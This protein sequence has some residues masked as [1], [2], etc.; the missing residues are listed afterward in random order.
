MDANKITARLWTGAALQPGD[1]ATMQAAGITHVIDCRSEGGDDSHVLGANF[2]TLWNPTADDGAPKTADWF[3]R[4][5]YFAMGALHEPK[6]VVLAH[7]AA[8]VN[9]GPST[10]YAILLSF[11]IDKA[12]AEQLIR[13]ARPQVG[14]RYKADAEAAV[15]GLLS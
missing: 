12:V 8:G 11:G 4:S 10:A 1:V 5:I 2:A 3:L 6:S 7:C 13:Q 15:A 9:R 14:L